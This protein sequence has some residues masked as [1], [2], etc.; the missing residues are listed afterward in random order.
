M[1]AITTLIGMYYRSLQL[2]HQLNKVEDQIEIANK[3]FSKSS[4][5]FE[6]ASRKE[7][8]VLFLEHRKAVRE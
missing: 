4:E 2:A 8:F 6:L 3:Q 1:A 5:Q 7:N